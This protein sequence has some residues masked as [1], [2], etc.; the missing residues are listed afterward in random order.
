M[1]AYRGSEGVALIINLGSRRRYVNNLTTRPPYRPERV[2]VPVEEE[3]GWA[4]EPMCM[5][6]KMNK[7]L[8][9]AEIRPPDL[10]VRSQSL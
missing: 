10:A 4:P 7:S 2:P 1:N 9:S 3:A 5:V 8:A 6:L